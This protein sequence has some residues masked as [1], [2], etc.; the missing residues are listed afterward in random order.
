MDKAF[1]RM[2]RHFRVH[3]EAFYVEL[4]VEKWVQRIPLAE[5]DEV[6]QRDRIAVGFSCYT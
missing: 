4:V 1:H 3:S 6:R 2:Q 5:E